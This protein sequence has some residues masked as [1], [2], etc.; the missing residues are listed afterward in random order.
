MKLWKIF[1]LLLVTILLVSACG[2]DRTPTDNPA[3]AAG[4]KDAKKEVESVISMHDYF[5]PDGSK[6]HFKGEEN[7]LADFEYEVSQVGENYFIVFEN[8]NGTLLRRIFE[9]QGDRIDMLD[10]KTVDIRKDFPS[11]EELE[12]MDP[13]SVYLQQPFSEGTVFGDWTIVQ[14]GV[15]VD[16]PYQ[17]FDNAI[18]IESKEKD[19]IIRK[20][21]VSGFGEVKRESAMETG[22]GNIIA[23]TSALSSL[24]K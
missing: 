8:S 1:T 6:G 24:G 11:L 3:G 9:I 14:T 18:V 5:P 21:F 16:T 17:A 7:E 4:G 23:A 15:K 13:I 2:K 10:S 19:V 20:Y 22:N 12:K